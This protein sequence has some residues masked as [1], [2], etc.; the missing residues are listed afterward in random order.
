MRPNL[1]NRA[2]Y[3]RRLHRVLA[4]IDAHLGESIKLERLARVANFSAFHLH[5]IF[6]AHFGETIGSYL[7]RRRVEQGATRLASQPRLRVLDAALAVGFGSAEAFTRAFRKHFGSAPSVWRLRSAASWRN[8]S[9]IGQVKSKRGQAKPSRPVYASGMNQTKSTLLRV[10]VASRPAVRIAYMRYQGP[11]GEPL[12]RFW[13]EDVY[14][15]LAA[16]DL[17]HSPRYGISHDDPKVTAANKC[18]YD[19]G[20]EVG[21]SFVPSLNTQITT[22][23]GGLYA[24]TKFKGTSVETPSIWERILREWLPASGYQLDARPCFEYY[25]TDGEYD[26]KTGAFTCELCMPIAKL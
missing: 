1:A 13:R 23:P 14:P 24:F 26:E 9:K 3:D 15:W 20:V 19:A 21:E 17:L 11:F 22:V 12:G 2:E 6:L 8:H 18:R 16:N 5:R 4:H 10:L 7:T 25:P